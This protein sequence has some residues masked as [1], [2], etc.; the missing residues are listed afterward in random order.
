[1]N[2]IYRIIVTTLLSGLCLDQTAAEPRS[3]AH[4]ER[5]SIEAGS[6]LVLTEV[7][8]NAMQH[9][10][11]AIETGPVADHA[12]ALAEKSRA[13]F[14]DSPRINLGYQMDSLHEDEGYREFEAGVEWPL[15][16]R[17]QKK[18]FKSL[19]EQSS[20]YAEVF[21]SLTRLKVTGRVRESIWEL[22]ESRAQVELAI[23]ELETS[24]KLEK[25]ILRRVELGDRPTTDALLAT[26]EVLEKQAA[27]HTS[28]ATLKESS[29]HYHHLT[30]LTQMPEKIEE[31]LSSDTDNKDHPILAAATLLLEQARTK[32]KLQRKTALGQPSLNL[33]LRQEQDENG[34]DDLDSLGVGFS[35]PI[36]SRK[37]ASPL[38]TEAVREEAAAKAEL[39]RLQHE[40]EANLDKAQIELESVNKSIELSEQRIKIASQ[41]SR[42][43]KLAYESGESSLI[44]LLRSQSIEFAAE[45][46]HTRLRIAHGRAISNIN[47]SLGVIP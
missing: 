35:L 34:A 39:L 42:L 19:A 7:I 1:M 13:W 38:I 28:E 26:Q 21:P 4:E 16:R 3:V 6:Q 9:A 29:H 47:Q 8:D 15:W 31:E 32:L 44:E 23:K 46:E 45:R 18:A 22:A 37:H 5:V 14:A 20:S 33:N 30:G 40:V 36:G 2:K 25:T 24:Q 11:E 41:S 12:K 17:S 43:V 10:P 27:L